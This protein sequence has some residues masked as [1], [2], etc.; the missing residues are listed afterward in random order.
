[1]LGDI[2]RPHGDVDVLVRRR[3]LP[4]VKDQIEQLGFGSLEIF[5]EPRADLPLVHA[6]DGVSSPGPTARQD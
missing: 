5:Y 2:D 6:H 1:M 4:R 3:L